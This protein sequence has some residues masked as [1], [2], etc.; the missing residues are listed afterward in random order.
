MPM[1]LDVR[2][3]RLIT[4][5]FA[6]KDRDE[7]E[8]HLDISCVAQLGRNLWLG[9]DETVVAERLTWEPKKKRFG[10]HQ[11]F[12]LTKF[13]QLPAGRDEEIDIEGMAVA[14]PYLWIT[15]SHS[16]TRG[17]A[18]GE[19]FAE[20][21]ADLTEIERETN[22]YFL[23]RVPL[24]ESPESPGDFEL[25][26]TAVDPKSPKRRLS[27]ARLFGTGATSVLTDALRFDDLMRPYV[28]IPSKDNGLDVEGLVVADDYVFL[29]LRGPVLRGWAVVLELAPEYF[30]EDYFTLQSIGRKGMLY[31][32][33][34]FDLMGLGIRDLEI[35]DDD[36][37]ILAGPTMAIDGRVLLLR[38]KGFKK[39]KKESVVPR[40]ELQ[41]VM[42]FGGG[43]VGL[44]GQNHPEGI[45]VFTPPENCDLP[46]GI[47]VTYDAPAGE[48]LKGKGRVGADL[49][50][51]DE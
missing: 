32:R 26:K 45:T 51:F 9:S 13:F 20:A 29:G 15:G 2:K 42:D 43:D 18:E 16:L 14:P 41:I 49:F 37:L 24:V 38:W 25:W 21:I 50:P 48:Y 46:R 8:L 11:G 5:D 6:V 28:D 35:V 4:L 34:F 10:R 40:D 7:D 3:R 47:M 17:K 39:R 36:L 31:R 44:R 27:A 23:G 1:K 22:R 19:S 30:C 33:H 12:D